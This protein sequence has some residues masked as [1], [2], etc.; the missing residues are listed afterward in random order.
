MLSLVIPLSLRAKPQT[1]PT[2]VPDPPKPTVSISFERQAI[3]ENDAIQVSSRF[4]NEWDQS[5]AGVTLYI[6]GPAILSWSAST[7][8]EW[9]RNS[10]SGGLTDHKLSL[11]PVGPNEVRATTLCVKSGPAIDV[12]DFNVSFTYD[13]AWRKGDVERHSF[14]SIDKPLKANLFGSDS[15]AGV[16]IALAAFIVPGLFF[17]LILGWLKFSWSIE[18]LPLGDKLIYSVLTSLP[19]LVIV[20]WVMPNPGAGI[21]FS[22]LGS[23]ALTG[24]LVGLFVGILDWLRRWDQRRRAEN[25]LKVAEAAHRAAKEREVKLSDGWE[26][27]LEKLLNKFP[28]YHKPR[29]VLTVK[30]EE[31]IGSLAD[32]T[33][34]VVAIVGW[35]Q[36]VQSEIPT[37]NR[38]AIEAELKAVKRSIDLFNVAK[39][40]K[41]SIRVRSPIEKTG[42]ASYL[43]R[44]RAFGSEDATVSL[45]DGGGS[46]ETL[47]LQ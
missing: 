42:D 39:K 5:L 29:A 7:C 15:V 6:D 8:E 27:L 37:S 10:Y 38:A 3:K 25:R 11:G 34:E 21:S 23:Y 24:F 14:I 12:G 30:E 47:T 19:L 22:K 20:N 13:Y 28:D 33:D 35:F 1:A 36:I 17:W 43:E 45:V 31:Y 40:Y 4:S 32:E 9:K 2:P 18:G 44:A 41:L 26:V 16:P 46:E